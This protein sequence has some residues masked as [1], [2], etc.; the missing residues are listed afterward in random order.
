MSVISPKKSVEKKS[1]GILLYTEKDGDR[2]YLIVQN[3]DT[4]AFIYFFLAW[5]IKKWTD[6]YMLKVIRGFSRD[7]L[8][9]LL[10]YPFDML[11]TDLYVLHKKGTFQ[12]QYDRAQANYNYFHNRKDWIRICH[13]VS[14]T[15]I[16]W[17]FSK[18]RIEPNEDPQTCALR[19]LWEETGINSENIQI[20]PD[21]EIQYMN[22]K[23]LFNLNVRVT[24]Y[25]AKCPEEIPIQY[26]MFE[27]TIRCRSVSNEILHARWVTIEEA[28]FLLPSNLYRFLYE[29]HQNWM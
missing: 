29:F 17:G 28:I 6:H 20:I 24:L 22:T 5:N 26:K 4:E 25:V 9:R 21:K 7:E 23:P 8:N 12:R 15:E 14:T 11:Y 13:N 27:N 2:R 19:E 10:Y 1:Y 16:K 3:R 18:G